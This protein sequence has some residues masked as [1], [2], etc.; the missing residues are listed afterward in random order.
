[1]YVG[2]LNIKSLYGD[3]L[4]LK[5]FSLTIMC[6]ISH[7]YDGNE[8]VFFNAQEYLYSRCRSTVKV[9]YVFLSC[10]LNMIDWTNVNYFM[11]IK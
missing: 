11:C 7:L 9:I 1:M 2:T 10:Y 5:R 3:L 4:A 8:K 6:M